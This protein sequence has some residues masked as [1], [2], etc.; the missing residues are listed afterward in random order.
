MSRGVGNAGFWGKKGLH[1][2]AVLCSLEKKR[3]GTQETGICML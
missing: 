1:K 3:L 2:S